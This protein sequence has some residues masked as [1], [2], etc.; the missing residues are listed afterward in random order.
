MN[1]RYRAISWW[2]DWNDMMWPDQAIEDKIHRR[3]DQAAEAGVNCAM[4]FGMHFRWDHMPLWDRLH[5]LLAF[6]VEELHA[7]EIAVF[8][9]HSSVLVHRPRTRQDAWDIDRRNRHHVPF[10][11][12]LETA[13]TWTFN[14]QPINDWRMID[15]ETGQAVY[16]PKYTAEQFCMNNPHFRLAYQTY[17]RKL[18]RETNIDGLMSDDNVH[19]GGWRTCACRWCQDRFLKDFG[20]VLPAATDLSFW[21][22]R[23]SEAFKDWIEM[24]FQD[25]GSF[26]GCVQ[27][28]LPKDF[29]LLSCCSSSD[30]AAAPSMGLTYQEYIKHCTIVMLEM[31]GNTPNLQGTWKEQ[32]ASQ[33]LHL[34]IA[35]DNHRPCLGLGYGFFPDTGFFVWALNRFLGTDTWFSTLPGRLKGP[36]EEIAH[37]ADDPEL[38]TEGFR[39][40]KAHPS[41]FAAQ[42]D[43]DLAVFFSRASRDYYGQTDADYALDYRLTCSALVDAS[44]DFEVVTTLPKAGEWTVLVLSSAVCLSEDE[45]ARLETYLRAGGIVAALGPTG[46]RDER[47]ARVS[48]P[49]LER[50][51]IHMQVDEPE[52]MPSFPP[53]SHPPQPPAECTGFLAGA[54]IDPA[55][56]VEV[57]IGAGRLYWTPGR[58]QRDAS[59]LNLAARI[60]SVLPQ[61]L[62]YVLKAPSGWALRRFRDSEHIYFIGLPKTVVSIPHKTISNAFTN[63]SIVEHLRYASLDR[64]ALVIE[65]EHLPR[66]IRVYSPDLSE[67]REVKCSA[68]LDGKSTVIDLS[69]ISR[70][71]I[72]QIQ[73]Q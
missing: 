71:F 24:R 11:P 6:T 59:K 64:D 31:G 33:T 67:P 37:L 53:Y 17:V 65:L 38:V 68:A 34:A 56:W 46:V 19:Y 3:A 21:G 43:A 73:E 54:R 30:F 60:A 26:L 1:E 48:S 45:I 20:H 25:S 69:G 70:F 52:R 61:R 9:H 13:A 49:W 18:V 7:R 47:A 58:I 44:I 15:I 40:E 66:S 42:P 16:L 28:A 8:D 57:E 50:Y 63:E 35:R 22:N 51:A 14:G 41:L 2:L 5:D 10:Y 29:P 12:S 72:I 4:I 55:N 39:W 32:M 62:P 27:E 23:E 36:P